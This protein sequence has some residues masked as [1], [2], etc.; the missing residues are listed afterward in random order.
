MTQSTPTLAAFG[1]DER[2]ATLFRSYGEPHHVAGRVVRVDRDRSVVVTDQGLLT[3]RSAELPATGDWVGLDLGH[4]GDPPAIAT[5][6]PRWSELAREDVR[7]T[8][9]HHV[10]QVLAANVD[11]V[12]IVAALDR[13]L[14]YTRVERGLL[15]G[16][17]SGATPLVALT[18]ADLASDAD[19]LLEEARARL[20]GV[21]IVLTSAAD[22]R[23]HDQLL[24]ALRPN[25]TAVLLG[26][27]GAGKSSLANLLLEGD[28]AAVAAVRAGDHKGRHTTVVRHLLAVPGGGVLID[29]PGVRAI[30]LVDA[31]DGLASTFPD[32]DTLAP[33]CQFRDCHH[34]REPGCA[35]Q[36]AVADGR[37]DPERLRSYDKLA[38]ELARVERLMDRRAG[39]EHKRE[40]RARSRAIRG[41][42]PRP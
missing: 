4:P 12:I 19:A 34:D 35:V 31:A 13:P 33:S 26:P 24:A 23:G 36:A 7:A 37:L 41:L 15:L 2:V 16:W 11:L 9:T 14:S 40:L 17:E 38:R 32:I 28:V 20:L 42:P 3:A 21:D 25:R 30:G 8:D 29:T 10:R 39:A 22:G 1:W 18:K 6:L 5:T 27:S